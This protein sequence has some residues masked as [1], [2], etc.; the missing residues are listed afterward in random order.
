MR[1]P[2]PKTYRLIITR[3]ESNGDPILEPPLVDVTDVGFV[4]SRMLKSWAK[5]IDE[6]MPV[7]KLE[8]QQEMDLK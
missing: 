3:R 2:M 7:V 8:G 6:P 4:I 5:R 1:A